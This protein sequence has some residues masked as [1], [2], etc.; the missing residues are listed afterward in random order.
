M[1]SA[2]REYLEK[3]KAQWP[4][5]EP[6]PSESLRAL[7]R[8]AG[9]PD[10]WMRATSD[11][12]SQHIQMVAPCLPPELRGL[13]E[14]DKVIGGWIGEP[15]I[16]SRRERMADGSF[17]IVVTLDFTRLIYYFCRAVARLLHDPGD[18]DGAAAG[19]A[20]ALKIAA[21]DIAEVAWWYKI[22]GRIL[23][24]TSEIS[25]GRL[26]LAGALSGMADAFYVGH[27]LGHIWIDTLGRSKVE[28]SLPTPPT[29]II[30]HKAEYLADGSAFVWMLKG[31]EAN[32]Y[33]GLPVDLA[34]GGSEIVLRALSMMERLDFPAG[35]RHPRGRDRIAYLESVAR[36]SGSDSPGMS[37]AGSI[38]RLFDRV[39][40]MFT[41]YGKISEEE[42]GAIEVLVE[43]L[44][45]VFEQVRWVKPT[46]LFHFAMLR[47]GKVVPN[48][49]V[50][51]VA[52]A[53]WR[54]VAQ[55]VDPETQTDEEIERIE[56][57]R[58]VLLG[59]VHEFA[60]GQ[61]RDLYL[62]ELGHAVA[63]GASRQ[64]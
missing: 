41:E 34:V 50:A 58:R 30:D 48:H 46:D 51:A 14:T 11:L 31:I 49:V 40:A 13:C 33:D 57:R 55:R 5:P 43:W 24:P 18:R 22:T 12:V 54:G 63:V 23:R 60:S 3:E 9:R 21:C 64:K 38:S 7:A 32:R 52:R 25:P 59:V 20:E 42:D 8:K 62:K 35:R 47:F 45:E 15:T 37:L 36:T 19:A 4:I 1:I 29:Y 10:E 53:A 44:D 2:A 61:Y 26:S 17:A 16:D 56:H 28:E 39:D 6:I 27:E